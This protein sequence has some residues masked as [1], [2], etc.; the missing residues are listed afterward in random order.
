MI[1]TYITLVSVQYWRILHEC[2]DV[3]SQVQ[4]TS[5]NTPHTSKQ[6]SCSLLRRVF[7]LVL[8]HSLHLYDAYI[9]YNVYIHCSLAAFQNSAN[10]LAA[11]TVIQV[12]ILA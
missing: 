9:S 12:R 11:L 10:V 6:N 1:N 5:E 3:F 4:R 8:S 2:G 7:L